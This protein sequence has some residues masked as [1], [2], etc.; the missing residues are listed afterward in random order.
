M[1]KTTVAQL[2]ARVDGIESNCGLLTTQH[3]KDMTSLNKKLDKIDSDVNNGIK[4]R[5]SFIAGKVE[6][7][8]GPSK[9]TIALRRILETG[10]T[11]VVLGLLVVGA[12]MLV[13]GRLTPDDIANILHAW[14]GQ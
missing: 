13:A 10:V 3:R 12:I 8:G 6:G 4:E 14:R 5:L 9:R 11:A 7:M 2:E 1:A